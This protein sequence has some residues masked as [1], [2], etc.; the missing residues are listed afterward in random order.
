M[1]AIILAEGVAHATIAIKKA[2]PGQA[3]PPAPAV[4][5]TKK[6]YVEQVIDGSIKSY[7]ALTG[8][9]ADNRTLMDWMSAEFQ[10]P[11]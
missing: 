10:K 11:L 3:V 8:N 5:K 7:G 2:A 1:N 9:A 6:D 4:G